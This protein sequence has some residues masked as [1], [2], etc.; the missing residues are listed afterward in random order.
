MSLQLIQVYHHKV[1]EILQCGGSRNETTIRPA[2]QKLL[3]K[4]IELILENP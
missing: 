4:N 3:N 2:F 1:Q